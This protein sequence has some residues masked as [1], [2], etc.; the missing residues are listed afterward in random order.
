M[1]LSGVDIY[2]VSTSVC[3]QQQDAS[4]TMSRDVEIVPQ[5]DGA[6]EPGEGSAALQ[7]D[8]GSVHAVQCAAQDGGAESGNT[9][10]T[11]SRHPDR[12]DC[13]SRPA[14]LSAVSFTHSAFSI[15]RHTILNL[16]HRLHRRCNI[17]HHNLWSPD[18]YMSQ[19]SFSTVKQVHPCVMTFIYSPSHRNLDW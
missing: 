11:C 17:R 12:V 13:R 2:F 14:L 4:S 5:G 6:T 15:T 7:N 3:V 1:K 10:S 16:N 8:F 18:S 9:H 19:D